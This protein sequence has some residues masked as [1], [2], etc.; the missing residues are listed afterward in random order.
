MADHTYPQL[1]ANVGELLKVTHDENAY[2]P[3]RLEVPS[4][5]D[6]PEYVM[7]FTVDQPD[8]MKEFFEK[9]NFVVIRDV[10]EPKDCELTIHEIWK[11]VREHHAGELA[12]PSSMRDWDPR[13]CTRFPGSKTGGFLGDGALFYRQMLENRQ[14]ERVYRAWATL[15]GD[16]RLMVNHDRVGYFRPTR[17]VSMPA[18]QRR[19]LVPGKSK[20][21]EALPAADYPE[22]RSTYNL[23]LDMNPWYYCY[24]SDSSAENS[25]LRTIKYERP[26]MFL[27]EN[28]VLGVIGDGQKHFQGL[29]NLADNRHDDGGFILVPG[30]RHHLTE[31]VADT[32]QRGLQETYGTQLRFI[33]IPQTEP[34]H[35]NAIRVTMRAGSMVIWDQCTVHGSAPNNSSRPRYAQFLKLFPV[36]GCSNHVERFERRAAAIQRELAGKHAKGLRLSK[37]GRRLFGLDPW[38]TE[39]DESPKSAAARKKKDKST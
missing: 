30:F 24:E 16:T 35:R 1:E 2:C 11:Y 4:D 34:V 5:P 32:Q 13:V 36:A 8:E 7:S 17:A 28:N 20:T 19:S 23:H 29:I 14:N 15:Y 25:F 12:I 21:Y 26:G 18:F 31:W 6:D 3:P 9:Y 27:A 10:L 33:P 38:P 39:A 37:L 22:L